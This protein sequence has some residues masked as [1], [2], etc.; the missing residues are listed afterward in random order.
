ME[1]AIEGCHLEVLNDQRALMI[2]EVVRN[3]GGNQALEEIVLRLDWKQDT[4]GH[5]KR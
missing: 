5:V 1:V 3:E 2:Q 4:A